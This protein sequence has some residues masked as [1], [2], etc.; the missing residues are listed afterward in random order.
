MPECASCPLTT[1]VYPSNAKA[2]TSKLT[3]ID[4]VGFRCS[5]HPPPTEKRSN[6]T[7][8]RHLPPPAKRSNRTSTMIITTTAL[9]HHSPQRSKEHS[10]W[11]S[12]LFF[13]RHQLR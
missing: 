7:A 12:G 11:G 9:Q 8:S 2:S 3:Y 5:C 1:C 13:R 4:G 10:L 6:R